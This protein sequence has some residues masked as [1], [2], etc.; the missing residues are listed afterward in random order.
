MNFLQIL[1]IIFVVSV[2]ILDVSARPFP[3][4]VNVEN[5]ESEIVDLPNVF[6]RDTP[7]P[8]ETPDIE[9]EIDC[10]EAENELS[11]LC[12][13]LETETPEDSPCET[14]FPSD[15]EQPSDVGEPGSSDAV[16]TVPPSGVDESNY[17]P[18]ESESPISCRP[19]IPSFTRMYSNAIKPSPEP[20][21][22]KMNSP[23]IGQ[24]E[25][26]EP[27]LYDPKKDPMRQFSKEEQEEIKQDIKEQGR[28][29]YRLGSLGIGVGLLI[30][31]IAVFVA[32]NYKPKT[33][34]EE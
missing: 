13:A 24:D 1:F 5:T 14:E 21:D 27:W 25:E 26:E 30:S 31:G 16:E 3:V 20:N 4:P 28:R 8:T 10:S 29:A 7:T 2:N 6:V 32:R 17:M 12:G 11:M 34:V 9:I 23:K 15:V 33:G 22:K 19:F 18:K